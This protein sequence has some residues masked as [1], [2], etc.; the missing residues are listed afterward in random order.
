[1]KENETNGAGNEVRRLA[2]FIDTDNAGVPFR[3][4]IEHRART[5]GDIVECRGFGVQRNR[6]W[7]RDDALA[8]LSWREST[9][10]KSGGNG[11]AKLGELLQSHAG[12]F[13]TQGEQG[14]VV[15]QR[16]AR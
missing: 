10:Q 7:Q 3:H 8:D 2:L 11:K 13:E 1:M 14:P 15:I 6:S 9:T 5:Y 16:L 4:E 12:E